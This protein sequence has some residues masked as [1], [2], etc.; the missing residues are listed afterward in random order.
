MGVTTRR[1]PLLLVVLLLLAG[2]IAAGGCEDPGTIDP[3]SSYLVASAT[4]AGLNAVYD[5]VSIGLGELTPGTNLRGGNG[6]PHGLSLAVTDTALELV[7]QRALNALIPVLIQELDNMIRRVQGTKIPIPTDAPWRE[8]LTAR[9]ID[10]MPP[11]AD[12]PVHG[13]RIAAGRPILTLFARAKT[14]E[15][16]EL[17]LRRIAGDLDRWLHGR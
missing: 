11:F 13:E 16:C 12:L 1:L 5:Q 6:V 15:A 17:E 10:E 8:S 4:D 7:V 14:M 9:S 2:A 3:G